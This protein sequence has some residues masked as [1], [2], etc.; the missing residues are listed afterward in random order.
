MPLHDWSRVDAGVFHDFH[1]AWVCELRRALNTAVER[2]ANYALI[3]E[4][5][6]RDLHDVVA[7]CHAPDP[8][9]PIAPERGEAAHYAFRKRTL[10]V[11]DDQSHQ[12]TALVQIV[13]PGDKWSASSMLAFNERTSAAWNRGLQLLVLDI[14]PA[15][16]GVGIGIHSATPDIKYKPPPGTHGTLISHINGPV[17]SVAIEPVAVGQPLPEMPLS[18]HT[19]GVVLFPVPLEA[20]YTAAFAG[21]PKVY[22]DILDPTLNT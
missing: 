12:A 8:V 7:R 14:L 6:D 22:R 3:E 16:P 9:L 21:I 11:R 4:H 5:R 19:D 2:E 1:L 20:T 13:T 10:T 15:T 17:Q 18:F